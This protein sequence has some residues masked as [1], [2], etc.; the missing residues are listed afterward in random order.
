VLPAGAACTFNA[1]CRSDLCV[2]DDARGVRR[3]GACATPCRDD[4]TCALGA[5]EPAYPVACQPTAL[6]VNRGPDGLAG[7]IDDRLFVARLCTGVVCADDADCVSDGG[8]ATCGLDVDESLSGLVRRCRPVTTGTKRGGEPCGADV[9]C[10]SGVCGALQP[11]AT[12]SGRACFEACTAATACPAGTS[13]RAGGLAVVT[14]GQ[15]SSVD[16]CAP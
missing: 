3:A 9:E 5:G 1:Q 11:P 12:E 7:T 8:A 16:S 13:C 14:R 6:L 4:S 2:L 10:R 15:V